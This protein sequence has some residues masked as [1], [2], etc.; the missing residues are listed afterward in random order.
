MFSIG[1]QL[2]PEF[3]ASIKPFKSRFGLVR[4]LERKDAVVLFRVAATHVS[5]D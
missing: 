1:A 2:E 3:G 5:Y 4:S